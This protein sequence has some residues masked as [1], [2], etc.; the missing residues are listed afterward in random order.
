MQRSD[1]LRVHTFNHNSSQ[2][3]GNAGEC[4]PP[5]FAQDDLESRKVLNTSAEADVII[6]KLTCDCFVEIAHQ[7]AKAS[8]VASHGSIFSTLLVG[9]VSSEAIN[10]KGSQKT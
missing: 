9:V 10:P 4:D 5:H 8:H 1:S 6:R 7:S 2:P 3:Q